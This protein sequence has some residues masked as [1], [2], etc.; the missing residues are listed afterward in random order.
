MKFVGGIGM[1]MSKI[2][3]IELILKAIR[4]ECK[5]THAEQLSKIGL[6]L[7]KELKNEN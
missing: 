4:I 1:N 3:E 6:R 2:E 5:K 7:I